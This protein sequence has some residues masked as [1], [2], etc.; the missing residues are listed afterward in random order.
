MLQMRWGPGRW[1]GVVPSLIVVGVLGATRGAELLGAQAPTGG[2]PGRATLTGVIRGADARPLANASVSLPALERSATTNSGG[3][4]R[5]T[6]LPAGPLAVQFR[7]IGHQPAARTLR[8]AAGETLVLDVALHASAVSVSELVVTG[9]A[10]TGDRLSPQDVATIGNDELRLSNTASLGKLLEAVPGVSNVSAG[11]SAGNVVIRGLSQARIRLTRD[12]VGQENFQATAR[13]VPPSNLASIDRVEVIRGPASVLYGSSAI[14]G[15]VNMIPR[16]LPLAEPGHTRIEGLAASQYFANNNE[17]Y[18][19]FDVGA[20]FGRRVAIRAGLSRRVADEVQTASALPYDATGR[21]GDPKYVGAVPFT[22]YEQ[23][24]YYVQAGTAGA[25]GQAQAF[26]DGYDG[27]NNFS[28]ASGRPTGVS[29]GNHDLRL[30]GSLLLGRFLLRPAFVYQRVRIQRAAT[31]A[32]SYEDAEATNGWDQDL[33]LTSYTGRLDALHPAVLGLRG[34]VGVE[35]NW[36]DHETRLSRIQPSATITNLAVFA[37]EEWRQDN[38]SISAGGRVDYREQV[39]AGTS[40]TDLLPLAQRADALA[41]DFTVLTGS[42][43]A[44]YRVAEPLTATVNLSTGFRAPSLIDLYTDEN[45]PVLGGWQ[46]GTPRLQPEHSRGIEGSVRYESARVAA[47]ATVYGNWIRNFIFIQ[48]SD[49]T[50]VVGGREL[51]VFTTGQAD[52]RLVGLEVSGSAE[53]ARGVFVEASAA[54]V[55][56]RNRATG[57]ELPLMP[58][59]QIRGA[60]RLSRPRLGFAHEPFVHL[61]ARHA[62]AKRIAGLTEPFAEFDVNPLGFGISSTPAYTLLDVGVGARVAFGPGSVEV[63]VAV[64]NL[65]DQAYRDFLDTQKGYALGQ[66]RNFTVRLAAPLV[67]SR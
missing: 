6:D 59:D 27:D 31:A 8:L 48:R 57:E 28:N 18:A 40:L 53:P 66:G 23:S 29:N 41:Q 62:R 45:R 61:G 49:R 25:W 55:R 33:R 9:T 19:H 46:E 22:N 56:T 1:S 37:F 15:A 60:L 11:P 64:D 32:L 17:R 30:K 36:Q 26:Y 52:A 34:T 4:Y 16:P 44:G 20:G 12:G 63:H 47:R 10:A 65:L 35:F 21:R 51:P 54:R 67:L 2:R 39:A 24:E 38:L 5:L 7:A 42:I 14:G 58:A 3:E 43:G 50:R 13:W